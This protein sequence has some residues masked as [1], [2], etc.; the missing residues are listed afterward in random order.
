MRKLKTLRIVLLATLLVVMTGCATNGQTAVTIEQATHSLTTLFDETQVL[1]GAAWVNEDSTELDT[2]TTAS[3]D[4]GHQFTGSRKAV[5]TRTDGEAKTAADSVAELWK[6]KGYTVTRSH[7]EALGYEVNAENSM[8]SAIQFGAN[9]I[10]LTLLG[11]S[12]C[13]S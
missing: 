3:G 13:V 6:K 9:E 7:D 10:A 1:V 4:E 12:D 11:G 5:S 8:R 2:C